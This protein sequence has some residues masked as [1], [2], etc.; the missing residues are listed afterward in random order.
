MSLNYWKKKFTHT[1]SSSGFARVAYGGGR[2]VAVGGS[3]YDGLIATSPTGSEW[4]VQEFP[5]ENNYSS[6]A[7]LNGVWAIGMYP[8]GGNGYYLK[9]STDNATTWSPVLW[10]VDGIS[11]IRNI[12]SSPYGWTEDEFTPTD[13]FSFDKG[14]VQRPI[15]TFLS[16]YM[17]AND[18]YCAFYRT[19]SSPNTWQIW[20]TPNPHLGAGA[21]DQY[22]DI[23]DKT[24]TP[25]WSV[26]STITLPSYYEYLVNIGYGNG[27]YWL[28]S[29]QNIYTSSSLSGPW[30]QQ[31]SW[32]DVGSNYPN[33]EAKIHYAENSYIAHL[34]NGSYTQPKEVYYS[35]SISGPYAPIFFQDTKPSYYLGQYQAQGLDV[36]DIAFNP[37]TGAWIGVGTDYAGYGVGN[38]ASIWS[39]GAIRSGPGTAYW[40]IKL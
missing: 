38:F 11:S 1:S 36:A 28:T 16:R 10:S 20:G 2:F 33:I 12:Q 35:T 32:I 13:N 30:I 6:V 23:V 29:T 14:W 9:Y 3:D 8:L 18:T 27:A 34:P 25:L 5:G 15:P 22:R 7:Y 37:V 31:L 26:R 4:T 40:G 24:A 19:S 21:G 39:S 17:W